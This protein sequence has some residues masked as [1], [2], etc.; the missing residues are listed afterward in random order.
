M[1]CLVNRGKSAV[2]AVPLSEAIP[3]A[4][5]AL[6]APAGVDV[7]HT[8]QLASFNWATLACHW[9]PDSALIFQTLFLNEKSH[10]GA[11]SNLG[12][13]QMFIAGSSDSWGWWLPQLL[14]VPPLPDK[15]F[16]CTSKFGPKSLRGKGIPA[17]PEL[18]L[19]LNL[20]L[21]VVSSPKD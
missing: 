6:L 2:W 21:L 15:R 13:R 1:Q 20:Y 3:P 11:K 18:C 12:H 19:L 9:C 4:R 8:Q 10:T 17:S 7:M 5:A 16:E 14:A